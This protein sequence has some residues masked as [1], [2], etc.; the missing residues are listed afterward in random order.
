[1]CDWLRFAVFYLSISLSLDLN[2]ITWLNKDY[3][4]DNNLEMS[5]SLLF[6]FSLLCTRLIWLGL[7]FFILFVLSVAFMLDP[8][9]ASTTW[10]HTWDKTLQDDLAKECDQNI[11]QKRSTSVFMLNVPLHGS[12]SSWIQLEVFS[13]S[14]PGGHRRYRCPHNGPHPNC[15]DRKSHTS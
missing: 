13:I 1:M 15:R 2:E 4:T 12:S 3:N 10:K 5:V 14:W 7:S 8:A 9:F 6:F 11:Y